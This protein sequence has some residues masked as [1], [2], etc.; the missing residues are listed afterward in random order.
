MR[1]NVAEIPA[2]R[3]N[4]IECSTAGV[5]KD[6]AMPDGYQ[7]IEVDFVAD[8][9]GLTMFHCHQQLHMNFG[10]MARASQSSRKAPRREAHCTSSPCAALRS[11]PKIGGDGADKLL[12]ALGC[13]R[14]LVEIA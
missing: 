9:T 11:P 14:P 13:C 7:E 5:T 2:G 1:D 6:V 10:F 4:S 8:N 3:L 12:G